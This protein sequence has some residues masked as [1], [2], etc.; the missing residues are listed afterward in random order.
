M[1]LLLDW[2]GWTFNPQLSLPVSKDEALLISWGIDSAAVLYKR[3][4]ASS[5]LVGVRYAVWLEGKQ[6]GKPPVVGLSAETEGGGVAGWKTPD[7]SGTALSH[8]L[9]SS[10]L[11]TKPA[12]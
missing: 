5:V 11:V 9:H 2:S 10:G 1:H 7:N 12:Y 6:S 4:A 3:G 8:C